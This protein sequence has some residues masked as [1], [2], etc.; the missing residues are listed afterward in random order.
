MMVSITWTKRTGMGFSSG[1]QETFT[2]VITKMMK[3]MDMERCNGQTVQF[4]KEN[5]EK[6]FSTVTGKCF[7][8]MGR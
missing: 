8:Q 7:F 2:E 1:S 4:T 3:G 5:G 6:A